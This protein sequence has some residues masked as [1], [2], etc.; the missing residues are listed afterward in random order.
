MTKGY[1]VQ[2]ISTSQMKS[3]YRRYEDFSDGGKH[4]KS[5]LI[6]K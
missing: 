1:T 3:E 2:N 5:V 4:F 6:E